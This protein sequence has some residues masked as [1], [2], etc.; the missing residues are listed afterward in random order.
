MASNKIQLQKISFRNFLS[1]GNDWSIV[2]LTKQ[3]A[4]LIVGR[5]MDS[6]SDGQGA[7]GV[8]KSTI[9]NAVTYALYDQ[10]ISDISKDNLVNNINQKQME[11]ILDYIGRDGVQYRIHR[12]RKMKAGAAGNDVVFYSDGVDVTPDSLDATNKAIEATIGIP[13]DMFVQIIVFTASNSPFLKLKTDAQKAFI[14]EL[15]GLTRIT[16]KADSLKKEIKDNETNI[17]MIQVKIDALEAERARHATQIEN[18]KK[19]AATWTVTN[20]ETIQQLKNGLEKLNGVDIDEQQAIHQT[21]TKL[22]AK[23]NDVEREIRTLTKTD[24][25]I[26]QKIAEKTSELQHLSDATCPYCKQ[27]FEDTADKIAECEKLNKELSEELVLLTEDIEALNTVLE[28]LTADL[29]DAESRV[30]VSNVK[31][32]VDMR[33]KSDQTIAR[34]DELSKATNPYDDLVQE[35]IDTTFDDIDYAEINKRTTELEHQ[36]FLLKLLT[37]KDSF[38]RKMLVNRSL[39]MLNTNLKQYLAAM[40]LPHS[41]EFTKEMTA[42]ITRFGRPLQFGNLSQ[43]QS[44]RVNFALAM[45]FRDVLQASVI[46]VNVCMFDEVL[47]HGLDA[48]GVVAAANIL[49]M[50]A[51]KDNSCMFVI[52][53]KD[54]VTTIFEQRMIVQMK[55]GFSSI[56]ELS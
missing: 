8:G 36:K 13:Y 25:A 14:E 27:S 6:T 38:I 42:T 48:V 50:K 47:D 2:D 44:A 32:L 18:A 56:V 43:G 29:A 46:P 5:D 53:H 40:N 3:G 31:E 35:L 21:I 30:T 20:Q 28:R 24:K 16:L 11:V 7:N 12:M 26:R 45:A 49:K 34:I 4:T 15:F 33:S 9:F 39:P 54:E 41:V 52:S 22:T 19:K 10:A 1:Y 17:K 51:Q 37:K 23:I 55:D